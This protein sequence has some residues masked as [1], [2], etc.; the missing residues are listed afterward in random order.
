MY[1][2]YRIVA[3]FILLVSILQ[4][5]ISIIAQELD[6]ETEYQSNLNKEGLKNST[7]GNCFDVYK[8]GS[9]DVNVELDQNTYEPGD[10]IYI[11]G[12]LKNNNIYPLTDL[13][14]KGK[15]VKID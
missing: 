14:V 11:N 7:L 10:V 12:E 2:K 9:V 5:N 13:K 3:S 15:I 4:P 6:T 8:F 1:K